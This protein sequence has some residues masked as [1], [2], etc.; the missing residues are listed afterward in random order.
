MEWEK[1]GIEALR[2]FGDVLELGFTSKIAGAIQKF[3]PK[4]HTIVE[5]DLAILE[6]AEK[7]AKKFPQVKIKK[8]ISGTFDAV[9]CH[10]FFGGS[11][12][13]MLQK[14]KD[15]LHK[16]E[17]EI[18]NLTKMR[19]NDS[20]LEAFCKAASR[21][22]KGDVSRFLM[23]LEENG[24]IKPDQR[25]KMEAKYHLPPPPER[26]ERMSLLLPVVKKCLE[27]HMRKGGRLCC[28]SS[29]MNE[30][31]YIEKIGA[32]IDLEVRVEKD[33]ILIEKVI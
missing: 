3:H 19:Y 33:F 15:L 9:F 11:D 2:P 16:I 32:S 1:N 21:T 25:K 31:G 26:K 4:S 22:S 20:E 23:E 30:I 6:K 7:W 8:E 29:L 13:R 27:R 10:A 17:E 24:Q 18:P 12:I 5:T 14:G 28:F